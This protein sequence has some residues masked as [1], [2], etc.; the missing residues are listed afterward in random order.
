MTKDY[1]ITQQQR[2][3]DLETAIVEAERF[4]AKASRALPELAARTSIERS[5]V[6]AEAKRSSL[7]LSAALATMRSR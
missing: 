2:I 3:A 6:Y 5:K 7:D 4:I 1:D